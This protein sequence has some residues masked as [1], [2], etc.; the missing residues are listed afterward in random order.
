MPIF[1]STLQM[2]KL[3]HSLSYIK[4]LR[5][6]SKL[7]GFIGCYVKFKGLDTWYLSSG[8]KSKA[9]IPHILTTNDHVYDFHTSLTPPLKDF[10]QYK[11]Y[12]H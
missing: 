3:K 7:S 10:I 12:I 8:S 4:R 5:S 2:R 1:I 6:R 9:V 11:Y